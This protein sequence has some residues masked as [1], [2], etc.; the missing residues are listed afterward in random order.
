VYQIVLSIRVQDNLKDLHR[1]AKEKGHGA[2]VLSAV[3][4]IV[5]FLRTQ[6]LEFGEPRFTLPHMK[7]EVRVGTVPPLVVI[8]GVQKE[9]RVVF[10][11]DFLPLPGLD[12]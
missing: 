5:A 9:R 1:R 4:R 6:P 8:Y 2:R 10:I 3:K 11:R 7:L 12:F